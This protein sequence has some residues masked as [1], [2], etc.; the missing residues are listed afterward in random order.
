MKYIL[1][2]II[3]LWTLSI[4][5]QAQYQISGYVT[6]VSTGEI[7]IGA[8]VFIPS[9]QAGTSTNNYGFYTLN[10]PSGSLK[11][12]SSFIGYETLKK[13]IYI[14]E[15]TSLKLALS[16]ST[17]I[18]NEVLLTAEKRDKNVQE[19][20]VSTIEISIDQVKELPAFMGEVDILK[21]IQLLPGVQSAGEGNA[22]FYVRG[23]G[24]DQ[25]LILLDEAVVYNAA[26]LLG[27]FSV[28][29][30]DAIKSVELIKGGMPAQYGGRLSS[31]LNISMRDGNY[32]EH[33]ASGGIGLISTRLTAEGPL[34][35]DTASYIAS[36]R[37]TYIDQLLKPVL[38]KKPEFEGNSYFFYD[39]NAKVNYRLSDKDRLF[40]SGYFGKDKFSF[41]STDSDFG[42]SIPWGNATGS[43]RWNHIF[44]N[45]AFLNTSLIFSDYQFEFIAEQDDFEFG[46]FSG[47]R[48]FNIK[49]DVQQQIN[50]KHLLRYG[51]NVTQHIF[52][53]SNVTG[54]IGET[55]I[56]EGNIVRQYGTE[57]G[58]YISD[59]WKINPLLSVNAGLRFS[60]FGHFGPF[61]RFV[62][63]PREEL[64]DVITYNKGELIKA[65]GGLEPRITGRYILNENA[66]LK[67]AFTQNYQYVH[68]AS[69]SS[70]A[71]PTDVWIP[72]SDRVG[73][74]LGRQYTIGYF[75]NLFDN[76]FETS[77]EI[78]YKHLE[79]LVEFKEGA[80]PGTSVNDNT[81][82]GLTFGNGQ[83]YGLEVF[84]KKRLGTTTGWI[85]YTL[86]KTTR[87]FEELNNGKTFV[88]TYDRVHDL[89]ITVSHKFNKK[90]SLSSV[91]IYGTGKAITLPE[92]IY[93][94]EGN[95][96][97]E[98]GERNSYRIPAYHRMDISA[99][100]TPN[101][102]RKYQ[103][104][105]VFSIYNIY[106]RQNPYL[107][108][109]DQEGELSQGT[110]K[111]T[112][113]QVS[114]F[115]IIPSV[116][117]NFKF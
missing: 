7:L 109:F 103:N 45:G 37:R 105:W 33:H 72:S 20:K 99:T 62:K 58:V 98:Y 57:F 56:N 100:Y 12:S 65:Y 52:T 6:D 4:S 48:D 83:S 67:A 59:E 32:Q 85:G 11:I 64:L 86:S 43:L 92:Q 1:S 51:I 17:F 84:L 78:Y 71:L 27:F 28:F 49:S 74:Q 46:I 10:V 3:G 111:I 113:K 44:N 26:H 15:N 69:I 95:L 110:T 112:A 76:Y 114:L 81:D 31:V 79:N 82:N 24:P 40:L 102:K 18:T 63:G 13:T 68:L 54:R 36:F 116:T 60:G 53:P 80:E 16:P 90:W 50:D 70:I 39:I 104:N 88:A 55:I 30:A 2:L 38:K 22:G 8:N 42:I 5:V 94:V 91:F 34:K 107:I 19:T 96:A 41:N 73:P 89:S 23:G 77:A 106:N 117:W 108:F 75:R 21:T 61:T 97:V 47:I 101:T 9:L 66:S 14:T 29:N 35:K 93:I 87:T 25:N 115:P